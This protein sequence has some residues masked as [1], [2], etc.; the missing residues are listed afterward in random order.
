MHVTFVPLTKDLRLSAK[1][2]IGNRKKLT[3]WQDDFWKHMVS[4]YPELERGESASETG[5]EH[6]PPRIFKAKQRHAIEATLESINPFN[7][8]AK[9]QEISKMLDVYIPAVEQMQT[10]LKKYD[11]AFAQ[12]EALKQENQALKAKV[13]EKKRKGLE[14]QLREAKLE[15][16][17]RE[18]MDLIQRIPPDILE[19]Y[20]HPDRRN[21]EVRHSLER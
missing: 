20:R 10:E 19:E 11:A 13:E 21:R 12:E 8:K 6:I 5:R 4:K 14:E 3:Q 17:Y 1:E 9:A 7:G 18:A 2:I 15:H 16:D